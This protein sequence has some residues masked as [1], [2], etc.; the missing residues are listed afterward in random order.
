MNYVISPKT[1]LS[2]SDGKT[3]QVIGDR[4][5][6]DTRSYHPGE[7]ADGRFA[8]LHNPPSSRR[9]SCTKS[10]SR[11][12]VRPWRMTGGTK[13]TSPRCAPSRA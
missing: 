13:S 11:R 3:L 7:L 2:E 10:C 6:D 5:Y 12:P 9:S 4:A 1:T 8:D